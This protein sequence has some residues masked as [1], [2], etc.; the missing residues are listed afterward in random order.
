MPLAF[1]TTLALPS[2]KHVPLSAQS[3]RRAQLEAARLAPPMPPKVEESAAA[4]IIT[5]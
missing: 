1:T 3:A 4:I 2:V 5:T